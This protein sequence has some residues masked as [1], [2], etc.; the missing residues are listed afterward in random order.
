MAKSFD[1]EDKK[2]CNRLVCYLF[3]MGPASSVAAPV[4]HNP[5][6]VHACGTCLAHPA[7][8]WREQ[9]EVEETAWEEKRRGRRWSTGGV[10][11]DVFSLCLNIYSV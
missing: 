10:H 8:S 4:T 3:S 6:Q 7:L 9:K 5:L 1:S 2:G 11:Q